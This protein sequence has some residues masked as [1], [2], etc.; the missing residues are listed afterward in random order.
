MSN[1]WYLNNPLTHKDRR[2]A[3]AAS[4]WVRSFGC[5]DMKP[6]IICRGPIRKEAMDVFDE[7]GINN[8]GILLSEKDSIIYRSA[9]APELRKLT[10]PSRVHR[11]PDYTGATK[12]ERLAR[13]DQIIGDLPALNSLTL[14]HDYLDRASDA[15]R[16]AIDA[17]AADDGH[18]L[19]VIQDSDVNADD[20]VSLADAAHIQATLGQS[21]AGVTDLNTDG[22]PDLEA[23]S[24][25]CF[26]SE[27]NAGSSG[28]DSDSAGTETGP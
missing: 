20:L 4:E 10:D 25:S 9:L 3:K 14:S 22:T 19:Y 27:G 21:T 28:G 23:C 1:N 17:W 8:Y 2:L 15:T 5:A 12:E 13:I 16:D 24:M 11:V 6:L 7:M 18:T 26:P